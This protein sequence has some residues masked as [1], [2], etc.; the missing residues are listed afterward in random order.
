MKKTHKENNTK[1]IIPKEIITYLM[2]LA[3]TLF[4]KDYYSYIEYAKLLQKS[5]MRKDIVIE[6]S[7]KGFG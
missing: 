7:Y 2:D 6:L 4:E 5:E 1:V 3:D